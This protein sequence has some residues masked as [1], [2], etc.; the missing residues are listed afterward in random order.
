[1][2]RY[3]FISGIVSYGTAGCDSSL[4]GVYTRV[5]SFLHWIHTVVHT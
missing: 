1:M 3:I 2:Y 4:P 5:E